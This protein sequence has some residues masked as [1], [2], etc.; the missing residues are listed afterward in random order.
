MEKLWGLR[1]RRFVV[2]SKENGREG[3]QGAPCGAALRGVG[4]GS[5]RRGN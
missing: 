4:L 3:W 1:E 5:R 2:T